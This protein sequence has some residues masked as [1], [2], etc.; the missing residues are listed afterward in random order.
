VFYDI[1]LSFIFQ[2]IPAT[3]K[4]GTPFRLTSFEVYTFSTHTFLKTSK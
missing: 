2:G 3:H 4:T 1:V